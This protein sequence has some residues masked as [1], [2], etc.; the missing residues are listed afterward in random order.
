MICHYSEDGLLHCDCGPAAV[1]PDGSEVWA[2]NGKIHRDD[3]PA[4]TL[5]F[6]CG[7]IEQQDWIHGTQDTSA[8]GADNIV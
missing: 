2:I 1:H 4:V 7:R 3:G 8:D 6:P 5:Y